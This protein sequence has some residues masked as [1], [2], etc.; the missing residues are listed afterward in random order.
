MGSESVRRLAMY[1]HVLP[2]IV[3]CRKSLSQQVPLAVYPVRTARRHRRLAA[4]GK[5][6]RRPSACRHTFSV[7]SGYGSGVHAGPSRKMILANFSNSSRFRRSAQRR[8]PGCRP[9][10]CV[11]SRLATCG[12]CAILNAHQYLS[13]RCNS[14]ANSSKLLNI[15]ILS[16]CRS[17]RGLPVRTSV[18]LHPA[19]SAA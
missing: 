13:A 5:A 7:A 15:G 8:A 14:K 9:R 2:S 12:K 3:I 10:H 4:P 16:D 18:G 17:F 1:L 11:S 6:T 19:T